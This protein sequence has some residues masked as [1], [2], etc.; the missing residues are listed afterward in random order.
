MPSLPLVD[1]HFAQACGPDGRPDLVYGFDPLCGWCFGFIPAMEALAKQRPDLTVHIALGGLVTGQRIKPYAEMASYIRQSSWRLAD[2]T[3][4]RPSAAF[5]KRILSRS[6]ILASSIPPS[7]AILQVRRARPA[8]ALAFAHSVQRAHFEDGEDLNDPATYAKLSTQLELDL[9]LEIPMPQEYSDDIQTE[10]QA[11]RALG[12]S[13]FPTVLVRS[14]GLLKPLPTTY[15]PADFVAQVNLRLE[16]NDG[17]SN[18]SSKESCE[19][20][21]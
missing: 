3:G 6:D 4:H 14:A 18:L 16:R 13:S 17:S 2:A 19:R 21:K 11:T 9:P 20:P 12:I 5:A 1:D 15:R 7:A 10:F 8:M